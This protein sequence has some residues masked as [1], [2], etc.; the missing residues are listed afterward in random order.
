M[1]EEFPCCLNFRLKIPHL[2]ES[3]VIW[4]MYSKVVNQLINYLR[5]LRDWDYYEV[6]WYG[7]SGHCSGHLEIVCLAIF[8]S[9]V[10]FGCSPASC[11]CKSIH[12]RRGEFLIQSMTFIFL[13]MATFP[14]NNVQNV[15]NIISI[16][17]PLL[18][19]TLYLYL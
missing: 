12:A 4:G 3:E 1:Q 19:F 5:S 9:A 18:G 2:F 11:Y 8:C 6:G 7:A 10:C 15:Y 16:S 14:Y 13:E 17:L